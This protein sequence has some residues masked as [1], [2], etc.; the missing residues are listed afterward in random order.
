[1]LPED[2]IRVDVGRCTG[3]TFVRVVHL[4]TGISRTR[5]PLGAEAASAARARLLSEIERSVVIEQ[6]RREHESVRFPQASRGREVA[7]YDLVLLDADTAGC[8]S[9]FIASGELDT[10]RLAILRLCYQG[11]GRAIAELDGEERIYFGRLENLAALVLDAVCD[12][13][14]PAKP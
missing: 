6:L 10:R 9:T 3:G 8:V 5:A 12:G 4:P 14:R 13:S 7:G 11:L 1:M 2:D